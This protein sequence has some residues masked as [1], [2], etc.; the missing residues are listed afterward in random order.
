VRIAHRLQV[1]D[2][3]V[4]LLVA[5]DGAAAHR[6]D[7]GAG[8][9][10]CCGGFVGAAHQLAADAGGRLFGFAAVDD[11]GGHCGRVVVS[12][13]MGTWRLEVN[14]CPYPGG[15]F[16]VGNLLRRVWLHS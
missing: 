10:P 14:E 13:H 15:G 4:A 2:K 1:S 6:A 7:V 9:V 3:L 8:E 5:V 11:G 12:L 16:V